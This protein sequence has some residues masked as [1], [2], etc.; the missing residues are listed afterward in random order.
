[1]L[2]RVVRRLWL[3]FRNNFELTYLTLFYVLPTR[4]I[5]VFY[6]DLRTNS[7]YFTVQNWL[8]GFYNR[9]GVFTARYVLHS[10]FCPHSVYCAVRSTY[11]VLPT[12]CVY[13]AVRTKS[14]NTIQD[15]PIP[16][17]RHP[18]L[19][20][21]LIQ[22]KMSLTEIRHYK[23]NN[24]CFYKTAYKMYKTVRMRPLSTER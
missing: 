18:R 20:N 9:D 2:S 4:C 1:M 23:N 17:R 13:C 19:F 8:V 10:T 11:Y 24:L 16:D 7:D 22:Q 5:Y 15:N 14:L 6:V 21:L 3:T 12:R